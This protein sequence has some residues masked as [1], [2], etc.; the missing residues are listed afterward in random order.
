MKRNIAAL[1]FILLTALF[2][3]DRLHINN[4][5]SWELAQ[6][7]AKQISQISYQLHF[8]IPESIDQKV[9]GTVTVNFNLHTLSNVLLDF[10]QKEISS[11]SGMWKNGEPITYGF[12]NGHILI[13]KA[14]LN[15]GSNCIT[16]VFTSANGSLNRSDEFLYTL[17]VPDRASTVFP[18]FDQPNLKAQFQLS[19]TLPNHWT[20]ISNGALEGIETVDSTSKKW[21]FAQT[22]PISTYLFAFT[23]G[24]FEMESHSENGR[25]INMYHRETDTDK[26][27]RNLP[28]LFSLHNQSLSWLE[29]FTGIEYPFDKL[30]F[31]LIPGFQYSGMEHPG[32]IFYRDSRLLLNENPSTTQRLQQANLI[33]HEVAHQWFGNLVTMQWFNDVWLKEVF[34]GYMADQ[35]VNPQYP[36]INHELSFI[37]SHFPRAYSVDRTQGANPIVQPLDNL[38]NAGTLYGD[39]IYHKSP[40]MMQQLEW[41][42]GKDEFRNGIREYLTTY[43]M[44]NATWDN[45]VEILNRHTKT[46]LKEWSHKWTQE[47]GLPMVEFIINTQKQVL[48]L[49]PVNRVAFP[50]QWVE[51]AHGMETERIWIES[52]PHNFP[53]DKWEYQTDIWVNSD[54]MAYGCFIP[55]N[56]STDDL[57]VYLQNLQPTAKSAFYIALYEMVLDRK[58]AA[59]NYLKLIVEQ[60]PVENDPQIANHLLNSAKSIFWQ[61]SQESTRRELAQPLENMLWNLLDS[62]IPTEQKKPILSCLA[63]VFTSDISFSKLYDA[64]NNQHIAAIQLAEAERT[65]LAYELMLRKPQLYQTIAEAELDRI[66]N[67][68]RK[69]QFHY[70]LQAISPSADE[71][72]AFFEGLK[73][74]ENRKPE[75]W[76]YEALQW[77]HHPLRTDFSM[78]FI[79]PS[80]E[81]LPEIQATGDIFFPKMWLDATLWGHTSAEANQIVQQWVKKNPHLSPN[82]RQKVLQSAHSIKQLNKE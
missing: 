47:T 60:L 66:N 13:P 31:V 68:D 50:P 64:W 1:G 63:S 2:G 17:L 21:N 8:D 77:L 76:V 3:C 81:L 20:G 46:N 9:T 40:I 69:A 59:E 35:I 14:H 10:R 72:I 58:L 70:T 4:G 15:E 55:L 41:V 75:P 43:S 23:A 42:M 53:I 29:E 30:D 26:L 80:L 19:L 48:R 5:V 79:E 7:R 27:Q 36:D 16:I 52:L 24:K 49:K 65:N 62:S 25:T 38:L 45:L 44:G 82:L 71:R 67:P 61:F 22:Q 12:G 18:C 56:L 37:L 51:I 28:N 34:A 33:A 39:I 32:A 11:I 54:G 6:S 74:A 73:D 78:R 57:A